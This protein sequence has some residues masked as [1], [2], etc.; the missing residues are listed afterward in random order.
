MDK[1]TMAFQKTPVILTGQVPFSD[2]NPWG[3]TAES[4]VKQ[5]L[6]AKPLGGYM[7]A[8]MYAICLQDYTG[9][10]QIRTKPK[11]DQIRPGLGAKP[12]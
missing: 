8:S 5:Y 2:D 3:A 4:V 1:W 12:A 7:V 11:G 9:V 10:T 6:D